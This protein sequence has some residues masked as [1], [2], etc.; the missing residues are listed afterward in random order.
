MKQMDPSEVILALQNAHRLM[1]E[2]FV[3]LAKI[4]GRAGELAV[5]AA[6]ACGEA[7][8]TIS[9]AK[10]LIGRDIDARSIAARAPRAES[11]PGFHDV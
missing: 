2:A 10:A 11:V 8:G 5:D 6:F 7:L 3:Q 1:E 4:R 9:R